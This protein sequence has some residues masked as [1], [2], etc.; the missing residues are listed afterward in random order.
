MNKSLKI[1]IVGT[2]IIVVAIFINFLANVIGITTWYS[3][4]KNISGNGFMNSV[5]VGWLDL[6]F[7][8]IIYPLILGATA[9]YLLQFLEKSKKK[10]KLNA[11]GALCT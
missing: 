3:F 5:E 11:P 8:F 9:Y 7:L 4:L 6:I 10:P 2:G 1:F